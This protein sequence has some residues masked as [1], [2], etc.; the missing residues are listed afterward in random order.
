MIKTVR[1]S[2]KGQI[3]IPH[4]I[5]QIMGI[6]QGDDLL[7]FQ[8]DGKILLEKTQKIEQKMKDDF[9]DIL[10]FSEKSLNKVWDNNED[11]IWSKY[12]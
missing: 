3:A 9:K 5:R 4:S 8:V 1:V 11:D 2:E 12:L 6:H 10:K 7:M